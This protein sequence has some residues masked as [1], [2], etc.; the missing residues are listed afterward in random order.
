M[1]YTSFAALLAF[2]LAAPATIVFTFTNVFVEGD[3]YVFHGGS[4]MN[5]APVPVAGAGIGIL[6]LSV[7]ACAIVRRFRR[8]QI[9]A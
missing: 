1:S 8:K 6:L 2:I 4:S 9:E 3:R 7:G 5:E